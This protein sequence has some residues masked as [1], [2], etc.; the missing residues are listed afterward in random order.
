MTPPPLRP[1]GVI[2][3]VS[4]SSPG[5]NFLTAETARGCE[6]LRRLGFEVRLLPHA[7]DRTGWTAGSVRDRVGDL[8]AAFLD[9]EIDAV[10]YSLGG[11]HSAQLLSELD[12][13]LIAAHP[14]ILCGYS[15]ATSLLAA[16][17]A[18][19][20]LVT[21]YGPALIP[22]FGELPEPYPETVAHFLSVTARPE[23]A[24]P[25]PHIP[26]QVVDLDFGRR[27]K[28]QRPRDRTEAPPRRVLRPGRATGPA[29]AACLP[30]LRDL[31]G[32]PWQPPTAGH[33]LFLETTEP[34]YSPGAADAD[35]W[36]LR[37]AGMLDDL[38]AVVLG[39]PIGWAAADVETWY[40]TVLD[41][42][43]GLDLPV[44]AEFEFGHTNPILTIPNGV[45]VSVDGDEVVLLGPAVAPFV[46]ASGVPFGLPED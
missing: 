42:L 5:A 8:H 2:G 45:E 38:A 11:L 18:R 35:L 20:G 39:R 21:F 37:N 9:P 6:A 13:D 16:V 14:K 10:V 28:E 32:T 33:V 3:V 29:L 15:D 19:T 7:L 30:S 24:G 12:F 31:I 22:Q 27:E 40:V 23:A 25:F 44:L 41:C 17:T 36:H 34:P 4:P 26:Y 43:A 1:G 46:A